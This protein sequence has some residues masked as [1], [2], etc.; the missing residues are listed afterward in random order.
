MLIATTDFSPDA[1]IIES[2]GSIFT[3]QV[4][5]INAA[6]DIANSIKGIFGGKFDSYAEEY[7]KARELAINH[8]KDQAKQMGGNAII[9]LK[10]Q[11]N[12]FINSD[13]IFVVATADGLVVT[14]EPA[15]TV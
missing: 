5:S 14:A 3:E 2:K 6:K 8:L 11:Y 4:I 1:K 13:I 12:Q 15:E 10:I 9:N 7:K